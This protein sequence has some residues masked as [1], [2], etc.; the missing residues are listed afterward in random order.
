M[1]WRA[2][3]VAYE[4]TQSF[5]FCWAVL[6]EG[7]DYLTNTAQDPTDLDEKVLLTDKCI[8][9]GF[10]SLIIQGRTQSMMMIGHRLNIMTQVPYPDDNADLPNRLY[11]MRTYTELKDG[12]QSVTMVLQNLTTQ[13]IHLARGHVIGLVVATNAVPKSQCSPELL[14]KLDE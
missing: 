8:I 5:Q 2:M 14:K 3:R 4:W 10:Q 6:G 7:V 13:P 9:P 12:S 11:V 1:E